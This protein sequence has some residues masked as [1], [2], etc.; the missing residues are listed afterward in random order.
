MRSA[1]GSL[2]AFLLLAASPTLAPSSALGQTFASRAGAASSAAPLPAAVPLVT[3]AVSPSLRAPSVS[4]LPQVSLPQSAI[5]A[6]QAAA[7]KPLVA[8][9]SPAQAHYSGPLK[10][11]PAAANYTPAPTAGSESRTA[12]PIRPSREG[13]EPYES[14]PTAILPDGSA[15]APDS[16]MGGFHG[17]NIPPDQVVSDQGLSARG[18]ME[19]WRILEH[20]ESRSAEASAFRGTTPFVASPEGDGGAAYWAD[21][22]GWVYE[23]R[24]VPTWDVNSDLEGRVERPDGTYRDN[25]MRGEVEYAV[26]AKVPI[27]C[28]VRW[29]QVRESATNGKLYVPLSGWAANPQYDLQQCLKFWGSSTGA[30]R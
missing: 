19:D 4:A 30:A 26:P 16:Y 9:A 17:T 2:L 5:P 12:Q 23:L 3:A 13:R 15:I 8:Y 28:I 1:A 18:P 6:V 27:E 25:L 24:G 11:Q 21:Q 14:E 10:S 20:V 22:G 7:K 29:G